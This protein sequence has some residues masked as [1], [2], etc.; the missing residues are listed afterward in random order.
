MKNIKADIA[1]GTY[2]RIY[3]L[4]GEEVYLMRNCL[5]A[6]KK[7]I[8]GEDASDVNYSH[9]DGNLGYDVNEL[10]DL[11]ETLPFFADHR[12][13]VVE[14]SKLFGADSGFADFLPRIPETTV[15]VIVEDN[16]DKR[17]TLYKEIK[18]EG[19]VC[20]FTTPQ[21]SAMIDFA[22]GYLGKYGKRISREDCDFLINSVG[23]D[24][25]NIVSELDKVIDYT[26]ERSAITRND[27]AAVCSMQI[28]NKIF[29]IV[30]LLISKDRAGA[31][32]IYFDLIALREQPL[33]IL[34]F[35]M[36][37]YLKLII[38][39]DEMDR[40]ASDADIGAAIHTSDW[41]ARKYRAKLKGIK[42]ASLGKA[43]ELCTDTEEAIKSGNMSEEI[44]MEILLANLA[45]L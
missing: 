44:G 9:F 6:L 36:K 16:A 39:K 2:K 3:L 5:T 37:Q 22:A 13:I 1:Q 42:A 8:L 21:P 20:E 45:S 4:Y 15:L 7:G 14:N 34:R 38:V 26:G 41:I 10:K 27:I 28:E 43:L 24:M 35:F 33:G 18:K 12:L 19:Y 17:T 29:D 25:Y 32:R 30:D 23:G 31:M 11:C 40:G